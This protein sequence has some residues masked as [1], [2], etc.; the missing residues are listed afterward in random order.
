M[1]T[2]RE[3]DTQRVVLLVPTADGTFVVTEPADDPMW[4]LAKRW[5]KAPVAGAEY[6]TGTTATLHTPASGN[7]VRLKWVHLSTPS[8][9]AE[10][11]VTVKLG[12]VTEFAVPMPAPGVFMRTAIRDGIAD[13]ALTVEVDGASDV[14]V[15]FELEEFT[16]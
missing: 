16:P 15:N 2:Y 3:G 8:T 7:A 9:A 12:A 6:V 1:S 4:T 11:V 13:A 5:G 10:C 14:Y